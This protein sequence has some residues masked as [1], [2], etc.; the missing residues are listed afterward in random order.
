MGNTSNLQVVI[1]AKD[2]ASS[3][4]SGLAGK[5]ND[6]KASFQQVA[7]IGT[8]SFAAVAGVLGFSISN[9]T[10]LK[11]AQGQL[12]AAMQSSGGAARISQDALDAVNK[13]LTST[14]LLTPQ[15]ATA[16]E[17]AIVPFKNISATVFPQVSQAAAD[18]AAR[19]G[20]DPVA[21]AQLLGKALDDPTQGIG[22]LRAA[23][24]VLSKSTQDQVKQMQSAGDITGAQGVIIDALQQKY[25]GAA[26]QLA[27]D[28]P[29]GMLAKSAEDASTSIGTALLPAV[30]KLVDALTPIITKMTDW[31]NKHPELTKDI[32]LL[33]LG[34]TGMTA[35]IGLLALA[36][37][38][39]QAATLPII[40]IIAAIVVGI[41]LLIAAVDLIVTHWQTIKDF[42][43]KL[44][45]DIKK[46][47]Q[48]AIN[49]IVAF[50]QP[51]IDIVNDIVN[52]IDKVGSGIASVA[53][54]VGGSVVSFVAG[55]LAQGGVASGGSSYIVGEH[56]A[57][58]FTPGTN[59]TVTPN[60][61]LGGKSGG[62]TVNIN[63][64]NYLSQSA[65]LDMGDKIV[66][67]LQTQMR[68]S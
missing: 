17:T 64:G 25:G 58:L 6:M 55:H 11:E 53:K 22:K 49:G 38:T 14:T 33:V 13:S 27:K 28:D 67:A 41:A 46:I 48:D 10:T 16:M 9:A 44:W 60:N 39:V 12:N 43:S 42:F 47:F 57:E 66:R 36:F 52:A 18:M 19:L 23:Q 21:A 30:Q 61:Q 63:G 45:D 1:S 2:D 20:T 4:I 15:V 29:M 54:S 68:G 34:I 35:V 59:G 24:I 7:E 40:G 26:A 65:A 3:V 8:A 56:G 50:F 62:I 51:L 5:L 32:A 37:I 31:I